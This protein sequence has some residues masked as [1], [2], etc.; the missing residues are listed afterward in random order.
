MNLGPPISSLTPGDSAA[1]PSITSGLNG[2]SP[3]SS[4]GTPPNSFQW[5]PMTDHLGPLRRQSVR[6][7]TMGQLSEHSVP[8]V[9]NLLT[10]FPMTS[11]SSGQHTQNQGSSQGG[12]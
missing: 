1:G 4:R 8:T 3:T 9:Q 5:Q 11:T 6:P 10:M 2:S 12:C 7:T